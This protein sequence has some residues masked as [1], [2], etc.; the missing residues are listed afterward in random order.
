M[1][2]ALVILAVMTWGVVSAQGGL[3]KAQTAA[4]DKILS[5]MQPADRKMSTSWS[6]AKKLVEFL[7]QPVAMA[8]LKKTFPK[9]DRVFFGPD[10]EGV[11]KFVVDPQKSVAGSGTFREAAAWHD[12]TFTCTFNPETAAATSFTYKVTK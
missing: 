9:A 4:I 5:A 2:K 12:F 6:D 8:E 10:E 11:K 1:R 7:C 3:S